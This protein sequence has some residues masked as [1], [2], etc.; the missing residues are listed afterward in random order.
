MEL[1]GK[2]L[3]PISPPLPCLVLMVLVW[4]V[5]R[6][7]RCEALHPR[8]ASILDPK[9]LVQHVLHHRVGRGGATGDANGDGAGWEPIVGVHH[10][11]RVHAVRDGVLLGVDARGAVYP[12]G[13]DTLL[14]RHQL[15]LAGVGGVEAADHQHQV[16]PL[17]WIVLLVHQDLHRVLPLL[18]GVTDG[19]H[20]EVVVGELRR[21][22]LFHHGRLK[23]LTDLLRL[24]FKH[25]SLIGDADSVQHRLGVEALRH[26][27]LKLLHELRLVAPVENVVGNVIGLVHVFHDEVVTGK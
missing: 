5:H 6:H 16:Q 2:P 14:L 11:V 3:T 27:V 23:Q 8:E 7:S 9:H 20:D 24:A 19:I 17:R 12:K 15:Q 13:G 26:R 22:V 10:L 18:S 1:D 21:A 25:G 4:G